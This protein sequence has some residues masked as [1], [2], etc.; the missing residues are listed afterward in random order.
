MDQREAVE[1]VSTAAATDLSLPDKTPV[2]EE[3]STWRQHIG[4]RG[5]LQ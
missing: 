4:H 5:Q 2:Y 1:V 3:R